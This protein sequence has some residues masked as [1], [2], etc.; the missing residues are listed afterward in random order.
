MS[1]IVF[2][3]ANIFE[4]TVDLADVGLDLVASVGP[5][6][7]ERSAHPPVSH[8]GKSAPPN[9][10]DMGMVWIKKKKKSIHKI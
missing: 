10:E 4:A 7:Y 1:A 9:L 3:G 2:H 5:Q 8:S 6:D